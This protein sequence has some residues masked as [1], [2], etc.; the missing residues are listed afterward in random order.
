ML[1]LD[2]NYRMYCFV[3]AWL[4]DKQKGIQSVHAVSKISLG[5]PTPF[6]Q[7]V[8]ESPTFIMLDGGS[9]Q[10]L[11]ILANIFKDGPF[12]CAAFQEDAESLNGATTAVAILVPEYIWKGTIRPADIEENGQNL[13]I[14]NNI[15]N[16]IQGAKLA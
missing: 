9:H 13:V 15:Q 5:T 2:Q 8:L 14:Q 6:T 1:D 10:N 4:S 11:C 12:P 7:W 3:N 16:I